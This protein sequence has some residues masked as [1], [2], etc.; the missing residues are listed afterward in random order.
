MGVMMNPRENWSDERLDDLS[1]K[2]DQ[3]FA[4]VKAE[5]GDVKAEVREGFERMEARFER[6]DARFE[7]VDDRFHALNRMALGA[8]AVIIAALVGALFA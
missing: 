3:G 8:C 5:I 1:G 6:I 4:N 2:V 7:K